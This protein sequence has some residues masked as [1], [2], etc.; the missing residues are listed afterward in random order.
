MK[1]IPAMEVGDQIEQRHGFKFSGVVTNVNRISGLFK[2]KTGLKG[3]DPAYDDLKN[4]K[5]DSSLQRWV[6][7]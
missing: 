4:Y 7:K 2:F 6:E 5:W 3:A 1:L